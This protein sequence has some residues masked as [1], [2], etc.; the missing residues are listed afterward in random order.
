[1]VLA[2]FFFQL[3]AGN[4]NIG[5]LGYRVV[6]E[7]KRQAKKSTS[8]TPESKVG[9]N[10]LKRAAETVNGQ[11]SGI[12]DLSENARKMLDEA[13]TERRGVFMAREEVD[14]HLRFLEKNL[15]AEK[16]TDPNIIEQRRK[17]LVQR[18]EELEKRKAEL[19]ALQVDLEDTTK[20]LNLL[21]RQLEIAQLQLDRA[22]RPSSMYNGL[23]N[24]WEVA[25][26]AQLIEGQEKER[27]HLAREIHD[28]PAQ[29]VA[30]AVMRL[31]FFKQVMKKDTVRAEGELQDLIDLMSE[32]L[33]EVRRFMFNLK[34]KSLAQSGL[35]NTLR[36]FCSD[37]SNQYDLEIMVDLPEMGG[38]LPEE[39]ELAVFRIVQESLH[40]V[41]KHAEAK[42]VQ[43][44]GGKDSENNLHITIK[45]DGKGFV[46]QNAELTGMTRGAG[47]P[48][49]RERAELAGG[50]L[51]V[52]SVL[53]Q[54]TEVSLTI[55]L[56][57]H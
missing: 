28:G 48:N 15:K 44:Y 22:E 11:I 17:T 39:H 30:N 23:A 46:P 21:A 45:D 38:L 29:V 10:L 31:R 36:E 54:G 25:L 49:M 35:V 41:R 53:G 26:R 43:I 55:S 16:I 57:N 2:K 56:D 32:S 14:Y 12:R 19:N 50:K 40:N 18:Q 20:R 9:E 7:S 34:P 27:S 37:F 1:M 5:L 24:P 13:N 3:V 51:Q 4:P 8:K 33:L 6:S 52:K 47:L 42:I